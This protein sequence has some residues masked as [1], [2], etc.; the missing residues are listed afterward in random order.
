MHIASAAATMGGIDGLVFTGGIG[1][2][3]GPVRDAILNRLA[4][5]KI[6]KMIIIPANEERYMAEQAMV[7]LSSSAELRRLVAESPGK[8]L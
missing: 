2:N 4:F 5:L 6:P 8:M 1:E 7:C 3:A